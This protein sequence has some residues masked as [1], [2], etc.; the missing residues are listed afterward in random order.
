MVDHALEKGANPRRFS[1]VLEVDNILGAR[2]LS[3][4]L[5]VLCVELLLVA[6]E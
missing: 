1:L 3:R 6:L 5:G 2:D 4:E